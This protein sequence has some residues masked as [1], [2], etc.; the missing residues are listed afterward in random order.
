[1]INKSIIA[2]DKNENLDI[3]DYGFRGHDG[4]C[5]SCGNTLIKGYKGIIERLRNNGLLPKSYEM[6]CCYCYNL[7][8]LFKSTD[9]E[10]IYACEYGGSTRLIFNDNIS[11]IHGWLIVDKDQYIDVTTWKEFVDII[12]N[13]EVFYGDYI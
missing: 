2:S 6:L 3:F 12:H 8:K 9:V 11:I 1:M 7:K 10:S 4:C 13:G 5:E